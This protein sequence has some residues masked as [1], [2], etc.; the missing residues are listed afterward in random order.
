M[1]PLRSTRSRI[2]IVAS[3]TF[4][5]LAAVALAAAGCEP[6]GTESL[7]AK[8]AAVQQQMTLDLT[9]W[10]PTEAPRLG[11]YVANAKIQVASVNQ[12]TVALLKAYLAA[13][14][15][16]EKEWRAAGKDEDE[17]KRLRAEFKTDMLRDGRRP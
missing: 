16:N 14:A 9:L 4:A 5:V 1:G 7:S 17:I 2:R 3:T 15:E 6:D 8:Q 10:S 13:A 12:D 11:E